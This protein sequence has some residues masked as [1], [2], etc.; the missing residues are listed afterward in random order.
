MQYGKEIVVEV[1]P[2]GLR[3]CVSLLAI[4]L[5]FHSWIAFEER[6]ETVYTSDRACCVGV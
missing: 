3:E 5:S 1:R 6:D 2:P 4:V